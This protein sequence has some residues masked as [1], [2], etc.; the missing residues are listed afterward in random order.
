MAPRQ[1][2]ED[3]DMLTTIEKVLLL[4]DEE[5]FQFV[6]TEH[7]SH[8]AAIAKESAVKPGVMLFREGEP[9]RMINIVVEGLVR[10]EQGGRLV[11]EVQKGGLDCWSFFSE[12][13]HYFSATTVKHTQ[14]LSVSFEGFTDL[15]TAEPEFCWAILKRLAWQGRSDM[16]RLT[17]SAGTE[18]E[19]SDDMPE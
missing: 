4:Q 19:A 17:E 15:L 2:N 7:L 9:C 18:G 16:V 11:R 8:L 5:L 14:I 6:Y 1:G 10:V 13:S 3:S 12:S